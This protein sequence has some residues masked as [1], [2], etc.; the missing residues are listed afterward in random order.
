MKLTGQG[1]RL[2]SC[3]LSTSRKISGRV[4]GREGETENEETF[5]FY[6]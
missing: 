3:I 5:K 4:G 2:S 6:I 1:I